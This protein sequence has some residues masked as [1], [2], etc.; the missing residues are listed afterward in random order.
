MDGVKMGKM[1]PLARFP[2]ITTN[3]VEEAEFKLSQ[4]ITDLQ[5]TRVDD[6]R[7]FQLEMNAVNFGQT[8][9]L[10]NRFGTETRIKTGIDI[11]YAIFVTGSGVPSKFYVDNESYLI[12]SQ[13]AAIVAPAKQVQVKR[14]RNSELIFLR[15]SLSDLWNHFEKLTA[16][17]HRGP[18]ILDRNINLTKGPGAM[19]NGLMKYL[20]YGL[21][22]N[23]SILKLPGLRKNFDDTLMTAMLSLPNNKRDQLYLD[24]SSNIA[25]SV[26]R[27]AEEYMRANLKE[28]I[29]ITDLIQICDCSRSVLFSTFR[30]FRGYTPM[31]FLTEQRLHDAREQILKS[32]NDSIASIA[33]DCGFVSPNWFSKVYRKRFGESPSFTLRKGR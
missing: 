12:S 10:Y 32:D 14:P 28:P 25:P 11:D 20:A 24:R 22:Y 4:S 31:E 19:L 33:L 5:I 13:K 15:V 7:C 17:H 29:N 21:N 23:D 2:I 3:R 6:R 8:S 30:N 9:L 26:V 18:L 1:R 27:K 16:R